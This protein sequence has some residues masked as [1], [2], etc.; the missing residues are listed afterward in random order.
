MKRELLGSDIKQRSDNGFFSATDLESIGNKWRLQNGYKHLFD[1]NE[2]LRQKS[3]KEFIEKLTEVEKIQV[4]INSKGK[5]SDTWIHPYIFIDMALAIS[6]E[7]KIS[8]YQ[9][10][11]DSLIKYRNNSG[12]SY[13]KMTGALWLSIENKS[14][15]KDELVYI[16]N[17]IKI[18][19]DVTDW[20]EATE[21][22][23]KLRDKIHEYI[24]L[25]SDIIRE[26]ENLIDVS[27]KRAKEKME[28]D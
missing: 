21:K 9:W 22:Q 14:K 23:L 27:V 1:M 3:V 17:R 6:P 10:I 20:N 13:K 16:A 25:L 11:Y 8:V 7:L 24:A 5:N 4:K 18:E 2:W 12:D 19:C 28:D 15:F 26:R